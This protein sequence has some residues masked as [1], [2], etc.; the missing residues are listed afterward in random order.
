[1]RIIQSCFGPPLNAWRVA[2]PLA[3]PSLTQ[4]ASLCQPFFS[5]KLFLWAKTSTSDGV[6]KCNSHWWFH[7]ML[8]IFPL[9]VK[10]ACRTFVSLVMGHQWSFCLNNLPEWQL[11]RFLGSLVLSPHLHQAKHACQE[12]DRCCITVAN[13]ESLLT[14]RIQ[15]T[16]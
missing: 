14:P 16:L 3:F 7:G 5:N 15:V 12:Q 9:H 10:V 8:T 2:S 4:D 11:F 6:I 13:R 1:M